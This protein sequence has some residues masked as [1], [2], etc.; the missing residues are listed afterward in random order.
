[1]ST[2]TIAETDAANLA[3]ESSAVRGDLSVFL[4]TPV[5]PDPRRAYRDSL[6]SIQV[7][8][9]LG[10]SYA[11]VAEAHFTPVIGLA[12]ALSFLAA[13]T[14]ISDRIRLGTAVVPLAFDNPLRLAE[15]AALVNSLSGQRLEF[16]VG[17]GNPRGFS[18]DAYN[19]F[20]LSE[21]NRD[22]LFARALTAVKTALREPI[23]AGGKAVTLYPPAEDLLDRI[24][25]AT[26][27]HS[28]AAAA[29]AAGDGLLLFR[30]T[31]EGV[32]G[33]IQ[34]V[35]IDSYLSSFDRSV[36]DPRIGVSRS[37]LIA[38]SRREAINVAIAEFETHPND[39]LVRP[40]ANDAKS[41]EE[42]LIKFD[43]AFG[44]V[45]DVVETL[46][47]D[48]AVTRSSNYLFSLPFAATGSPL[49]LEHLTVLANEIH[50]RLRRDEDALIPRTTPPRATSSAPTLRRRPPAGQR[51]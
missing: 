47:G 27:D 43:I 51:W 6:D 20:G 48:A 35:L 32:A 18:T 31:P 24:W 29:G 40:E 5:G 15:T 9:D 23:D 34:S 30:T 38:A 12:A 1:M 8:D 50:P 7:A 45:D 21:D 39:H 25:Q 44:S 33:D 41:V 36:G 19:A 28:T 49:Y 37:V 14:Q 16:G 10:Y 26:G 22:Q 13:A 17:K 42:Y 2:Q 11:W 4:T 3:E 46:S